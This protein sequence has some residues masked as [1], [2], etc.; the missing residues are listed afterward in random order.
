MAYKLRR[1]KDIIAINY[2]DSVS[3]KDT[4]MAFHAHN[5]EVADISA[6]TFAAMT[7]ISIH[8]G[9]VPTPNEDLLTTEAGQELQNWSQESS[10]EAKTVP[11]NFGIRGIAIN[12][13]QICNLKCAY[14]AAGGDGTYGEPMNQI[15]V[16]QTLPQ[17]KYFLSALPDGAKFSISFIGGEPLL[18]PEAIK[19][20]Y[21]YTEAEGAKR[22]ISAHMGIVTNGT[23]INGKT[24]DII[25]SMK[26]HLTISLDGIKEFNDV[27]RP[28][29]NGKSTTDMVLASLKNLSENRG[30]VQSIGIAAVHSEGNEDMITNYSF[31]RNLNPDWMEFNIAYSE[32][33]PHLQESFIKQMEQIAQIA[34]ESGGEDELRKI[35]TFNHYFKMF[36]SQ[37]RIENH[38]GAGKSYL[39]V[40][41]KNSLYPCHWFIGKKSEKAG[42]GAQLNPD[43]LANYSKS[44]IEL[45]NCQSCWARYL[46]GGGCMYIH[47]EH[48]GSKHVKDK[49]FCER[50]RSLILTSLLYYKL[51]RSA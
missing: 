46:C 11:I 5:M 33:S 28:S 15:S 21:D 35:K 51:A 17:L 36:D 7:E 41:S 44:L 50:T 49:L 6:E 26:I 42:Q 47:S 13:N 23:L 2:V 32:K 40:D 10:A 45:N 37:L 9:T 3:Q 16:E 18:H 27:V 1:F 29:K 14:C 8:D 43:V 39:A 30:L 38:C 20:I 25:R 22:N 12:V 19:A 48:T 31:F 24:L 34:W 4:F